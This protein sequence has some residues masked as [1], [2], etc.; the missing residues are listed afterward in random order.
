M[1]RS[2]PDFAR[3]V[4]RFNQAG[5]SF[6]SVT[7]SFNTATSMGRLTLNVL[8]SV[9]QFAREV[10][11]ERIRDKIAALKQKGLWMAAARS[12]TMRMSERCSSSWRR[13]RGCPHPVQALRPTQLPRRVKAEADRL[14]LLTK[15]RTYPVGRT[16]GGVLFMR[17][18]R[19]EQGHARSLLGGAVQLSAGS[20]PL[21]VTE[22]VVR[23][24]V[25]A[26]CSPCP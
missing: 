25:A 18:G 10:T 16:G 12:A 22:G 23:R 7:Q 8:L 1:T 3:L 15:R 6:V 14:G 26:R 20:G 21:V 17:A 2:L 24:A 5:C 13:P 11:A 9:A 4:E 19:A